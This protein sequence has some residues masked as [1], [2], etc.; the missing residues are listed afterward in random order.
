MY[1]HL[2]RIKKHFEYVVSITFGAFFGVFYV[3][4][5]LLKDWFIKREDVWRLEDRSDAIPKLNAQTSIYGNHKTLIIN[6]KTFHYVEAGNVH[7]PLILFLHGF[8]EFWYSWRYQ[9]D[10]LKD[11]NHHLVAID[12]RGFGGSYKPRDLEEYN[13]DHLLADIRSF[14]QELSPN[15]RAACVVGHDWGGIIA[16]A[17]AAQSWECDHADQSGYMERLVILNAPHTLVISNNFTQKFLNAFYVL[18]LKHLIKHPRQAIRQ[19]WEHV[20]PCFN[21]IFMSFYLFIFRLPFSIGEKWLMSR[22]LGIIDHCV[23]S[24]PAEHITPDDVEIYKATY[25]SDNYAS[26]TCSLNYYRSE[27]MTGMYD[28]QRARG[29]KQ[30]GFIGIPTLVIWGEKDIALNKKMCLDNLEKYVTNLTIV[31]VPEAGHFIQ[32][33]FPEKINDLIRKFITSKGNLRDIDG[34]SN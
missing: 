11:M 25:S 3:G 20:L 27:A 22:D 15:G 26:V 2:T 28:G 1:T 16:W 19:S 34:N 6:G 23:G 30:V 31:R 10:G 13:P 5:P 17:A 24:I 21:Q 32:Q 7:G 8:P 29:I 18:N 14:I 33:Q 9:L 4:I 12:M